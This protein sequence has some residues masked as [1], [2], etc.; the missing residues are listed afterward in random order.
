[1]SY[2]IFIYSRN[3]INILPDVLNRSYSQKASIVARVVN[4]GNLKYLT[5]WYVRILL[6][7]QSRNYKQTCIVYFRF[8][9]KPLHPYFW[10]PV[11]KTTYFTSYHRRKELENSILDFDRIQNSNVHEFH[12]WQLTDSAKNTIILQ[13]ISSTNQNMFLKS[14]FYFWIR[15]ILVFLEIKNNMIFGFIKFLSLNIFMNTLH[16]M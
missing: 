7:F 4:D 2:L 8:W 13:S 10:C 15:L 6:L 1:M 12:A 3:Y 16:I 14:V 5:V 9:T 11:G